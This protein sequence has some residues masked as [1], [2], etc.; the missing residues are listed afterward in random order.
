MYI[1]KAMKAMLAEYGE[2]YKPIEQKYLDWAL[3]A[4][5]RHIYVDHNGNGWCTKC[6]SKVML[7]KTKHLQTIECPNCKAKMKS[8]HVWRRHSNRFSGIEDTVDWY[9]FPEVLNDHTLMLRYVL[10][11]K[12]DTEPEY[13]ERARYILDF[14]NKKEYTLEF[15]WNKKQWE[16]SASDY[17]RE[18]GMGYTYRRFCCLQGELYPHT[19]KRFNKIDNLKYIKFN[20]AMFSR[21]YVSSVVIN[22]SQKSVMYEKLTKANLYGLIA[23]DLG[24]YSHYYDVPYDDTQTELIKALGLNRNTYKYLKKNQSIRVLKFLKANPNVTEKEFET[25]KLLDFSSELSELVTSYNL[26]YGKTLKY[27]RKASEE[28]K[29]INFVRDYRDYL[30]TLDKLGYPL[31]SQY[32]YPTNFRKEDERVQQELRERN[33]RRRNMTKKEI[34]LEEARIDSIVNNISKALREN[35]EL[36]RWMK[37]SDGLK[38]IVPESV[39]ELTD[40]GIKLH[41]CL[42]NY[43]KEIADKQCLIFFIRKLNDPTHAYI[44]MEYRH[45][46]VRQLRFDKN[47]TVTDNK[48]VQFADALA[49][50]LNQLNIMNE[51]RRTA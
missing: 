12:A 4:S 50:K 13:G 22:A 24:S 14:K 2:A 7:P 6:E 9:V 10:V 8:L 32:C 25:A 35:E 29:L 43:A 16:Y 1:N 39:G 33:E 17:F 34:I 40:E 19:M 28:K 18:T 23:E 48:I 41:N 45:G 49:A 36:K 51:L 20:K 42:K 27:V 44:A 15:S 5:A 37:G 47:V 11:Y 46:E 31:D 21:W 30:N 38:V 26:H 3:K